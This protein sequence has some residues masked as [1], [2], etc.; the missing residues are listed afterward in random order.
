MGA[1]NGD[2]LGIQS[3]GANDRAS[4]MAAPTH[5]S[6]FRRIYPPPFLEPLPTTCAL[7]TG[8]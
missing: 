2:W 5:R 8:S 6:P 4:A 3:D 1:E 7:G